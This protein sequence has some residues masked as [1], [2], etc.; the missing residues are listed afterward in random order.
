[1]DKIVETQEGRLGLIFT[2]E[3]RGIEEGKLESTIRKKCNSKTYSEGG[4]LVHMTKREYENLED[5]NYIRVPIKEYHRLL[6][7][8]SE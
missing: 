2:E 1:M 8:N 7:R 6:S 5:E 3:G 4:V